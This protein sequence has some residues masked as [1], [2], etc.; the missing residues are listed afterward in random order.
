[1]QWRATTF[2]DQPV[3]AFN[4]IDTVFNDVRVVRDAW[5]DLHSSYLDQRL[6]S[7]EGGQIRQ[8]KL[9]TLLQATAKN[10][11][12]ERDFTKADLERLY[13]PVALGQHYEILLEQQRKTHEELFSQQK[14]SPSPPTQGC[15]TLL[16]GLY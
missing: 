2:V 3:R 6:Q 8:D 5:S 13:N 10:L 9:T 1:M 12:Y 7:L 15:S 16:N 4:S 11:G 14:P